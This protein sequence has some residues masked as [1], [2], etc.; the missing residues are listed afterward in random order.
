LIIT[1]F[2]KIRGNNY[3]KEW[4]RLHFG[5]LRLQ[6]ADVFSDEGMPGYAPS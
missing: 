3:K 4:F 5:K 1:K 6:P 2:L